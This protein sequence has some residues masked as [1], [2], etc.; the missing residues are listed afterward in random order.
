[1]ATPERQFSNNGN[2]PP[3]IPVSEGMWLSRLQP[4]DED[5]QDFYEFCRKN[6]EFLEGHHED[7]PRDVVSPQKAKKGIE[8]SAAHSILLWGIK[9]TDHQGLAGVLSLEDQ[10]EGV[11]EIGVGLDE[12]MQNRG[13]ATSSMN[14][15]ADAV[16]TAGG[17]KLVAKTDPTNFRSQKVLSRTH[18]TFA[19]KHPDGDFVYE[20][21]AQG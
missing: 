12:Q 9:T 20:L 7:Y 2:L 13:V 18:F 19:Y 5:A 16:F 21:L 1:M 4:T 8:D 17:R 11:Y 3:Y 6:L 10:G 15:L 14:A